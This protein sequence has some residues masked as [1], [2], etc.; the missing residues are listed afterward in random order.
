M[1]IKMKGKVNNSREIIEIYTKKIPKFYQ[2]HSAIVK[3]VKADGSPFKVDIGRI[4]FKNRE[5]DAGNY[6]H[7]SKTYTFDSVDVSSLS[8]ER[9]VWLKNYLQYV[10]HKGWRDETLRGRLHGV[11]YFFNFCDFEGTKPDTLDGLV[12]EYMNYQNVLRQR[13]TMSGKYSLSNI[14]VNHRLSAARDFVQH[15]FELSN[16]QILEIIP[17]HQN[18]NKPF[19]KREVQ[20]SLQDAQEYLQ[21]CITYFNQFADAILEN[22]YPVNVSLPNSQMTDLY[23]HACAGT[24]LKH[25]PNCFDMTGDPLPFEEIRN[26][27][28]KNFK[29]QQTKDMFY[30]KTLIENRSRWLDGEITIQKKY[31]Y[32]LSAFC[33]FQ[34][35]LGFTAANIQP[36]LDL[37]L[38]DLDISKMGLMGF[39][40]KFKYRAGRKVEFTSPKLLKK[41]LYKYLKLREWVDNQVLVNHAESYLFVSISENYSIRRLQRASGSSI[42]KSSPL[43]REIRQ[44]P[45]R[46]LRRLTGEYF[47][48]KSKGNISLVAKKLNNTAATVAKNYTS[49]DVES[50]AFEIKKYHNELV[51]KIRM[52]NRDTTNPIAINVEE[53]NKS[54]R[55]PSGACT[56]ISDSLPFRADGFNNKAP[57]PSCGTF[58]SCLFCKYFTIHKDFEDIHK[59][60]SL[61][62]ALLKTSNIRNDPEHHI[63]VVQ[64]MLFRIE[65]IIF[66]ACE[67]HESLKPILEKSEECIEM[68]IYSEH[69]QKLI[70]HLNVSSN[71]DN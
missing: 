53:N 71:A 15:A 22:K 43:M 24:T 27:V 34:V 68:G 29:G 42:F 46:D 16:E 1:G 47:I 51:H 49:I 50:Q 13:L 8:S 58:E 61:R 10:F 70:H 21:A 54:E 12:F 60:L 19:K 65:E 23:W 59:L 30:Q 64:P 40:S 18:F 32:N 28:D 38:S 57:E 2:P 20:Y 9:I 55:I 39:A 44:I 4:C 33:F 6:Y 35:Y 48:R 26:V 25:L 14:S 7:K 11:R 45:S 63:N 5:K 56:N 37:E 36:T 3:G 69:W 17:K 66:L 52:F 31:A 41:E 62:E 67:Q